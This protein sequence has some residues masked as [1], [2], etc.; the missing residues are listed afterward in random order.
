MA[1]KQEVADYINAYYKAT[2]SPE[3]EAK[4]EIGSKIKWE[5]RVG[6]GFKEETGEVVQISEKTYQVCCKEN[7]KNY[8]VNRKNESIQLIK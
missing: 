8:F 4:I 5:R 7:G 6:G 3:E 1:T 2:W